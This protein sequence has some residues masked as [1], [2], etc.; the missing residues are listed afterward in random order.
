M[1]TRGSIAG[2]V[3]DVTLSASTGS[4]LVGFIASGTGAVA[5]TVQSKERDIVSVKDFGAVGDGVTDD[6]AAF[7][8]FITAVSGKAGYI[9]DPTTAY[10]VS[11][12]FTLPANT[13]L[14]GDNKFSTKIQ[15]SAANTMFIM[16]NGAALRDL[17]LDGNSKAAIGVSITG[18]D[19]Q[20]QI[21]R[22][23]IADFAASCLD[24]A[25]TTAGSG[26]TSYGCLMYRVDGA[27]PGNYAITIAD[28]VQLTAVPRK[29]ANLETGGYCAF[30]FGGSNNTYVVGSFIGDVAYSANSRGV[31]IGTSRLRGTTATAMNGA[32]NSIVGCD[33]FPTITI[34]AAASGMSLGPC[35]W[36]NV[37][38]D[39]S[40]SY[41]NLITHQLVSFTP[42]FDT[43][44]TPTTLGNATL[45]GTYSRTGTMIHG[46]VAIT[47][48]STT[49]MGTGT[50]RIGLPIVRASTDLEFM[51]ASIYDSSTNT[52][53]VMVAQTVGAT[54]Y[55]QLRYNQA[56]TVTHAA[57]I[58]LA[59]G[60]VINLSFNY[61]I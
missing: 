13:T 31:N 35:S 25:A 14:Y 10:L 3:D 44:T 53:Y 15:L 22:C 6:T 45:A 57:P 38:L 43:A 34:A 8:E 60:D 42:T 36:N 23:K 61:H 20:Q 24:F 21:D 7:T 12:G 27:T 51:P 5:R 4:N 32:N 26:F 9:P 52:Y 55:V 59:V 58:T 2:G 37:P 40:G 29:F 33:V 56:G 28:A 16:G 48:G 39:N 11:G 1:T 50:L 17:Y 30:S 41:G 18:T 19:G 46:S 49:T 54:Q 47:I